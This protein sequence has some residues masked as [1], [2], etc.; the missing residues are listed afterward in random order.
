LVIL[1][2]VFVSPFYDEIA[3]FQMKSQ[4]LL[5]VYIFTFNKLIL[6]ISFSHTLNLINDVDEMEREINSL[7]LCTKRRCKIV[8]Y[9]DSTLGDK[10]H[11][12]LTEL[13]TRQMQMNESKE[14]NK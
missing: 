1:R 13:N 8:N 11:D 6:E 9:I 2:D 5:F 10:T 14:I 12:F 3:I 4:Q 7:K